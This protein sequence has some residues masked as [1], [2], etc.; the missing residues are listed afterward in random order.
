MPAIHQ[1]LA[2]FANGDAISN[3]ARTLSGIFTRWGMPGH[4]F[5]EQK[6]ILPQ[7]RNESLDLS[8]LSDR[9]KPSDIAILHLSIGSPAN[10]RFAELPCR[11]VI[12]YHNIT[13]SSYFEAVNPPMARQLAL[14]RQQAADLAG[15]ADCVLADSAFN[16]RELESIGYRDVAILPLVL[17]FKSLQTAPDRATLRRFRD[18][19][20][21]ILF[22]GRMVPN[23][24]IEDVL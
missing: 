24:C 5:C 20:R 3:E 22:V 9:I 14:G 8:A 13:P 11:K 1:L 7:L 15:V 4:L 17:D 2:G 19:R 18:G 16:A 23:K 10:R 6:R 21:N 12:L